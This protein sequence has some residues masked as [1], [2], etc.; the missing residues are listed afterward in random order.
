ML[1]ESNKKKKMQ[2]TQTDETKLSE[3]YRI[4]HPIARE[5]TSIS[6]THRKLTKR[7][8]ILSHKK[9]MKKQNFNITNLNYTLNFK[10]LKIII[11]L[12]RA[13][14]V[15][16]GHSLAR[17][18]IRAIAPCLHHS[19]SKCGIQAASATYTTARSNARSFNP[20][21]KARNRTLMDTSQACYCWGTTGTF[22]FMF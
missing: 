15:A 16:Y 13:G 5:C 6:S 7:D 19:H 9:T 8:Y 20:L 1:L 14:P 3:V 21:N 12:F 17:G 18:R 10:S 22:T 11:L 2:K 4:L